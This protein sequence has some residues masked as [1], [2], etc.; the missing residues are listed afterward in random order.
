[1]IPIL[2][3]VQPELPC[4]AALRLDVPVLLNLKGDELTVYSADPANIAW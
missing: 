2:R 3:I 1:M 4:M